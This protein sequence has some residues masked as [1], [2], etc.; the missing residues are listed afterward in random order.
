M[1]PTGDIRNENRVSVNR[2][3]TFY[4]IFRS[5]TR[6]KVFMRRF[7]QKGLI[8]AISA[9]YQDFVAPEFPGT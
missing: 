2:L 7:G 1:S 3:I 9:V 4:R 6:Q 8:P 5:K